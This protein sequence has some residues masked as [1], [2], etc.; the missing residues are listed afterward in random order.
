MLTAAEIYNVSGCACNVL[1]TC[2]G[3]STC[4]CDTWQGHEAYIE[5]G[6]ITA[7]SLLPVSRILK[8]AK[9]LQGEADV[10]LGPLECTKTAFGFPRH[11][12]DVRLQ[13]GSDGEYLIRPNSDVTPFLVYCDVTTYPRAGVTI[14]PTSFAPNTSMNG[15]VPIRYRGA[16]KEQVRALVVASSKCYMPVKYD[17]RHTEVQAAFSYTTY[18]LHI[19]GN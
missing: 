7:K 14:V 19:F 18:E 10:F 9:S 4:H 17:C 2:G 5:G 8:F 3:N 13:G 12:E 11:C 6:A 16:T 1:G 15:S